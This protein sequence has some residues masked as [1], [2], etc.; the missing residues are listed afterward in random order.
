MGKR[1]DQ[2]KR[3]D[4][5]KSKEPPKGAGGRGHQVLPALRMSGGNP[6]TG[7]GGR[8]HQVLPAPRSGSDSPPK[9]ANARRRQE[10]QRVESARPYS[11]RAHS[12]PL[13]AKRITVGTAKSILGPAHEVLIGLSIPNDLTEEHRELFLELLRSIESLQQSF[14]D[15]KDENQRLSDESEELRKKL[16]DALPLWKRAWETFVLKGAETAGQGAVFTA[17]F[18]A[19]ATYSALTA[20]APGIPI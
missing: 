16:D 13:R 19:G 15:F 7:A 20:D 2:P 1:K 9:D 4:P 8:G 14:A 11:P 5:P 3:M 10:P 18:I 17:G 6:P 12:D